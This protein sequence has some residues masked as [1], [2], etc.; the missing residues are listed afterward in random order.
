MTEALQQELAK[1]KTHDP[2]TIA[3][4]K[5]EWQY[6]TMKGLPKP[7][8]LAP[9]SVIEQLA[10]LPHEGFDSDEQRLR[11]IYEINAVGLPVDNYDS[12]R[13]KSVDLRK[14]IEHISGRWETGAQSGPFCIYE[15]LTIGTPEERLSGIIHEGIHATTPQHT[16][17]KAL[18]GGEE[19]RKEVV[20]LAEDIARQTLLTGVCLSPYQHQLTRQFDEGTIGIELFAEETFAITA[21]MA[22]TNRTGLA[23]KDAAQHHEVQRQQ[24]EGVWPAD[25]RPVALLSRQDT[26]GQMI[27]DGMDTVL[28]ILLRDVDSYDQ[29][30][31]H[32]GKLKKLFYQER[33][34]KVAD[35]RYK[36]YLGALRPAAYGRWAAEVARQASKSVERLMNKPSDKPEGQPASAKKTNDYLKN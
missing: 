18:F 5:W 19:S 24:A 8:N 34:W 27:L 14:G 35:S 3:L 23:Q 10:A 28:V 12:L 33:S 1:P 26:A 32:A 36:Q 16:A 22:L 17:N 6:L 4:L 2:A 30:L 25:L 11:L 29:L 31:A 13:R 9:P 21:E 7:K 15:R 20:K